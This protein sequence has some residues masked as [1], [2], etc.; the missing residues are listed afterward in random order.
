MYCQPIFDDQLLYSELRAA[1]SDPTVHLLLQYDHL[2]K[3][4]TSALRTI[5]PHSLLLPYIP[6]LKTHLGDV[7]TQGSAT[8]CCDR[9]T[10][11]AG[12][13]VHLDDTYM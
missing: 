7:E 6:P 5:L 2:I 11:L 8:L 12:Y 4:M 13:K 3:V 1:A 9:Y 10:K